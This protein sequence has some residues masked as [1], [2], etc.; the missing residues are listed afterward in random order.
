[1]CY[2]FNISGD[3]LN[4]LKSYLNGRTFSVK[5]KY[6]RG[7]RILLVYGVPQGSIL[8]P[9]L[10]ILY[11]SDIPRIAA[12]YDLTS[13]GY[14]DDSQL[15]SGF[16]PCRNFTVTA[17]NMRNCVIKL[18]EWMNQNHLKLNVNKTEVMFVGKKNDLKLHN[19]QISFDNVN[20]YQSSVSDS[21]KFLGAHI[22]ASLSMSRMISDC[23]RNCTFS[24]K[25][26]KTIKHILYTKDNLLLVKAFIISKLDYCNILLSTKSKNQLR[27]LQTILNQSIRF[28]FSLSKREAVTQYMKEAHI[29]PVL[30]RIMFKSCVIVYKI[31]NGTAP[32]Y[33]QGIV[34]VQ[35]P[36]VHNLRSSEDWF[37]LSSPAGFMNCLQGAMVKNWNALPLTVRSQESVKLFKKHLKTYYFALAYT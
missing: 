24:L 32:S 26:L 30:Y 14:A 33:L 1:M 4:W 19:L 15:Y 9:L 18:E 2:K 36:S 27:P 13:H 31:L 12:S 25:K 28:A 37:K 17:T 34:E 8:G 23:V 22:D 11:I 6:V 16:D 3:V 7:G 10:F 21:V 5:I 20:V 35:P 29:L